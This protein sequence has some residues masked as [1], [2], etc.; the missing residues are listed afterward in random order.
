LSEG[1]RL[2]ISAEKLN[3]DHVRIT[4]TDTGCG[5]PAEAMKHIFEPFFSTK[6]KVGGTGLGLSIT[7]SLVQELGGAIDVTSEVGVGT[8]F[9]I[10]LPLS[11]KPHKQGEQ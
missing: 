1:G 6:T 10:T 8:T 9:V 11:A 3:D 5:I 2:D 4:V 7:Y